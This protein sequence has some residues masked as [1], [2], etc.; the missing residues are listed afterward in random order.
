MRL[1]VLSCLCV[2]T[3]LLLLLLL[4]SRLDGHISSTVVPVN[5]REILLQCEELET[6]PGPLNSFYER[7]YSDRFTPGAKDIWIRNA[8]IWTGRVDG[9]E[10][11]HGDLL[12]SRG[13][14]KQIGSVDP[15]Y[16][17]KDAT[18]EEVDMHGAW[19]TPGSVGGGPAV[20]RIRA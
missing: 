4:R 17:G 18:L 8:T 3:A 11:I 13:L 9:L 20:Y 12:L 2:A 7:K 10:T 16:L 1:G 6:L 19:I 14:I 5:A 15:A